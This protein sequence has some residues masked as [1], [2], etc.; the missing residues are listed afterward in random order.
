MT[1]H[2]INYSYSNGTATCT[3]FMWVWTVKGTLQYSECTILM[4]DNKFI[5]HQKMEKE[6]MLM[7]LPISFLGNHPTY[8]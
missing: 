4:K 8:F 7:I 1:F 2:C 5:F 6:Q 3:K